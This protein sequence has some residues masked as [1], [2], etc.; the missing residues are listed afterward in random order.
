MTIGCSSDAPDGPVIDFGPRDLEGVSTPHNDGLIM[1][2]IVTNY[3]VTWVSIDSDN[4]INMFFREA[5][6][7]MAMGM[8]DL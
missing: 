2:A 4:W 8:P 6:K 5:L 1:S 7:W 3:E